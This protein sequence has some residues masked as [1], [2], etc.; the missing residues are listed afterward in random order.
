M[1][2]NT[3]DAQTALQYGLVNY[4]VTQEELLSKTKSVLEVIIS[5]APLA[6]SKCITAANAVY[7][8]LNGFDLEI[9]SF[10]ACFGTEDMKEGTAAFLEKRK[11]VFSGK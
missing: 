2:G 4:V 5:K 1:T 8:S 6:I 10:G 11:P 3:I 7:S 9:E